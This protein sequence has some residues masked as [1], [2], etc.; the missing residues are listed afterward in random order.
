MI[1][2]FICPKCSEPMGRGHGYQHGQALRSHFA[3]KHPD[4]WQAA[5]I[6]RDRIAEFRRDFGIGLLSLIGR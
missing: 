3:E 1:K 5:Q 2:T 4:V 6:L